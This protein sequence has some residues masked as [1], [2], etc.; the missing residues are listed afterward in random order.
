MVQG[1]EVLVVVHPT[2]PFRYIECYPQKAQARI[3]RR[4]EVV[5]SNIAERPAVRLFIV[6]PVDEESEHLTPI[7]VES[8]KKLMLRE[9]VLMNGMSVGDLRRV[10]AGLVR[11]FGKGCVLRIAGFYRDRCCDIVG[12]AAREA[13]GEV[14]Y[15]RR[16]SMG[17]LKEPLL[18]YV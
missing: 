3:L 6:G 4:A 2:Y 13:G 1:G 9:H 18:S 14:R 10:V 8:I 15:G 7:A 11:H 12:C 16:L 17:C 5:L